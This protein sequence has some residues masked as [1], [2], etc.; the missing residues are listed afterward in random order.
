MGDWGRRGVLGRPTRL[1][2][3]VI[4]VVVGVVDVIVRR[5]LVVVRMPRERRSHAA[6]GAQKVGDAVGGGPG[7]AAQT[8]WRGGRGPQ[9]LRRR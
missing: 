2:V 4:V 8:R 1:E 9:E 7:L 3:H 5:V 6:E